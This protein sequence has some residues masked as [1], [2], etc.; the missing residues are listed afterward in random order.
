MAFA[1]GGC[2]N[3][4]ADRPADSGTGGVGGKIGIGSG[5]GGATG[6][7]G[8][9]GG[10]PAA[11]GGAG[12]LA[13]SGGIL[14]TGGVSGA[15]GACATGQLYCS[16]AC[17][18]SDAVHCGNCATTCAVGQ[19]CSNSIC[20]G[21]GAGGI[22]GTG[23]AGGIGS[24]APVACGQSASLL[25]GCPTGPS[26]MTCEHCQWVGGNYGITPAPCTIA[27]GSALCVSDCS[28]CP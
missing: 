17:V 26:G 9:T 27:S 1:L 5:A 11:S 23:G 21:A 4:T 2:G 28:A 15:G 18:A 12:G 8:E 22:P 16:G 24:M 10:V 19:V 7:S 13:G 25:G 14:A 6:G 3:V 20:L